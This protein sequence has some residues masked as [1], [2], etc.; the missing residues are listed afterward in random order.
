MKFVFVDYLDV[1]AYSC[2]TPYQPWFGEAQSTISNYAEIL[3]ASDHEVVVYLQ[4]GNGESEV[5]GVSFKPLA[6]LQAPGSPRV[7]A[8]VAIVC[9]GVSKAST[10]L[11]KERLVA[12]LRVCWIPNNTN[13]SAV[14][15][16]PGCL[17]AFD[18]FAFV[19]DWLRRKYIEL[20]GIEVGRTI[21]MLNGI[22]PAFIGDVDATVKKPI[23]LCTS[24]ACRGLEVIAAA[25]PRIVEA[26]PEAELH[27][28]G[29]VDVLD[30]NEIINQLREMPGVQIKDQVGQVELSSKAKEA[31]FFAYPAITNETT[32]NALMETGASGCL[33]IISDIGVLGTYID[34]YLT[35]ND[36]LVDQFIDRANEYME[37]FVRN[38]ERFVKQSNTIASYYQQTCDYKYVVEQFLENVYRIL[39]LKSLSAKRFVLAQTAFAA[40][41]YNKTYLYLENTIPF[42]STDEKVHLYFLWLGISH[43]YKNSYNNAVNYFERAHK[44]GNSLQLCVNL[45]LSYEKLN[46]SN[47]VLFWCEEALKFKFDAKI[48]HKVM[49]IVK[50]R[51]YFDRCK[52]G[53]YLVSLWNDD[54]QNDDWLGLFLSHGTLVTGDLMLV[55]K[56]EQGI[57]LSINLISKALARSVLYKSDLAQLSL[58]R[59]NIDK[60]FSNLL[61]NMNYFETNNPKLW[62][63]VE[64]YMKNLPPL[65]IEGKQQFKKIMRNSRKLR[66]GF[67]TGDLVY[68]PVS[69]VLNG[70]VAHF[71]KSRFETHIFSTTPVKADVPRI[72]TRIRNDATVYYDLAAKSMKEIVDVIAA[73]DI[74]V[75]IEMTGHTSNAG[76]LLN[77]AR[78]KPAR[79]LANYFAYPNTYGVK[80]YDYKI[81]DKHVFPIGLDQYYTESFCKIEGG[82]HTYKPIVDLEVNKIPHKGIVF[83]CTN[84]PKKYRP[85]WIKAVSQILK[86]VPDSRLKMRYFNLEDP[87][88]REFYWKEFE[89]NGVE[90]ERIDLDLG[91]SLETYFE[92]YADM[93]ICLDPFP[94]NGGTINIETLYAGIPYITLIGN[95]YVSRVGASILHQVGHPELIAKNIDAYVSLAVALAQD[96]PRLQAYKETL[97]ED[98]IKSTLGDNAAFTRRFEDACV[99]MLEEKKWLSGPK[100]LIH[101]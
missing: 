22:P 71:D 94:Y 40:G 41:D 52:W 92:S 27:T 11:L 81:G 49:D 53:S 68:H 20:Y 66:I 34:S 2:D 10:E 9:G 8:D 78:H 56:H 17:Y 6:T 23:F 44:Y 48:V 75:L 29:H 47:K 88:I 99:W 65:A 12:G 36:S 67:L 100:L 24:H 31:A 32:C 76:D 1:A 89:K 95:N 84:N 28:Y 14:N 61:L 62:S 64:Y 63:Y 86:G 79:V 98:M 42:F 73:A 83:G 72:Q 97:R 38:T 37:L 101:E 43:Y 39:N 46:N 16:L 96:A 87:S 50:H 51:S 15:D 54:I 19:S 70:I 35:Y 59:G 58:I 18:V 33:P 57:D 55:M 77:I 69:Y 13:E 45:I 74:D 80:E 26:W 7:T 91:R 82:F 3:A 5:R 21:L 85:A 90:R 4:N 30:A 25:W 60:L 93:D